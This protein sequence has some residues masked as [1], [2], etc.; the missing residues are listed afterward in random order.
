MK[1][2]TNGNS[3]AKTA[4]SLVSAGQTSSCSQ[5]SDETVKNISHNSNSSCNSSVKND[6]MNGTDRS[7]ALSAATNKLNANYDIEF[8]SEID[9]NDSTSPR[10]LRIA[11]QDIDGDADKDESMCFDDDD[12]D[13]EPVVDDLPSQSKKDKES[14]SGGRDREHS[15][16]LSYNNQNSSPTADEKSVNGEAN[17]VFRMESCDQN[18]VSAMTKSFISD[19]HSL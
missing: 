4:H 7:D 2:N 19:S 18:N 8:K 10:S 11:E 9:E 3:S 16:D 1:S 6:V 12:S 14:S 17:R 5:T 15:I 13:D